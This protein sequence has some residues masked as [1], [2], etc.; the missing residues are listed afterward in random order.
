MRFIRPFASFVLQE[1]I[2]RLGFHLSIWGCKN[3]RDNGAAQFSGN[4]DLVEIIQF[5]IISEPTEICQHFI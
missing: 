3:G 1:R 5:F 2:L 4:S